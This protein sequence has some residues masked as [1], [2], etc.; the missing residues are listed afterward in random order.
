M[1][2]GV[3]YVQ[4]GNQVKEMQKIVSMDGNGTSAVSR[5]EKEGPQ[6]GRN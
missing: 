5:A 3:P 4:W 2:R 6:Q 1:F